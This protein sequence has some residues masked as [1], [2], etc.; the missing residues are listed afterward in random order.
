MNTQE[1]AIHQGGQ[2]QTV[3]CGHA[4]LV[5][6]F[7]VLDLALLFERE[8]LGQMATLVIPAQQVDRFGVCDL[9]R[10]KWF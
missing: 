5:H 6:Y 3:K 1:L 10:K 7:A 8:V 4:R 2:G 9:K